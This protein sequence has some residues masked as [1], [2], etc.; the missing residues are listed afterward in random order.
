[1]PGFNIGGQGGDQPNTTETTRKH[2]YLVKVMN[3]LSTDLLF[4]AKKSYSQ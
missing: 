1:M 4:F 3:P 2:R